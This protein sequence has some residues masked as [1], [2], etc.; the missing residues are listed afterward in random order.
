MHRSYVPF[1][2]FLNCL[3]LG[4]CSCRT[5]KEATADIKKNSRSYDTL[6]VDQDGN[7]YPVKTL[8]DRKLW[9]A[10]NL[11]TNLPNSYCYGDSDSNCKQYGRLYT[12]ESAKQGC[13]WLGE[14][15]R[16]PTG[17]EGTK[18][19]AWYGR[20]NADS[21]STRKEAFKSLMNTGTSGFNAVLGGG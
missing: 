6:I 11:Y 12:W 15:W 5:M 9:I 8:L 14:G 7:K 21:P 1:L 20:G 10:T 16:L 13:E 3:L 4:S 18:L 2:V 17:E 19:T